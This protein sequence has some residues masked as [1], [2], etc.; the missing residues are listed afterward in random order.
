[1]RNGALVL[2]HGNPQLRVIQKD[3]IEANLKL[4][5]VRYSI[6]YLR[7]KENSKMK[8]GRGNPMVPKLLDRKA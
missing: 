2:D 8:P 4:P 1:M 3:G 6:Q 5:Q 7:I